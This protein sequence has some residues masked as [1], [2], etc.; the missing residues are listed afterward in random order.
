MMTILEEMLLENPTKDGSV[1]HNN[2]NNNSFDLNRIL[3]EVFPSPNSTTATTTATET[4]TAQD[5]FTEIN[6][7]E[8]VKLVDMPGVASKTHRK[9]ITDTAAKLNMAF[10]QMF[11]PSQNCRV[12]HVNIDNLRDALFASDV[13]KRHSIKSQKA[14]MQW[15]M[16]QN[17]T[18]KVKYEKEQ[19]PNVSKTAYTKAVKFNFFLGLESSWLYK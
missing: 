4:F 12:P 7:A 8:P 13:L 9:L 14:L 18:L 3:V 10:P 1:H 17:E 11:K 5:I 15:M 6:K 16:D 2:N 19:P